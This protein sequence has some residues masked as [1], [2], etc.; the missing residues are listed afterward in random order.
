MMADASP[1]PGNVEGNAGDAD[2]VDN[3]IEETKRKIREMEEE[4]G[5]LSAILQD[6]EQQ[7]SAD[8]PDGATSKQMEDDVDSRSVYVGQV[9]YEST[10]EELQAHFQS[11]GTINR[12]TII[13]DKFTGRPKGYAYIEF[14]S[15]EGAET[16]V[17]LNESI[18]RG[19]QLKV[20]AKRQNI[21][22]FVRGRGR[23]RGRGG[24]RGGRGFRGRRGRGRGGY[25]G[26]YRG[27]SPY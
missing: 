26:G 2:S 12:V 13:C 1:P 14:E 16:A 25:R 9:D 6:I 10:P 3:K 8:G 5:K 17:S 19:R 4:D 11:C 7:M 15:V 20:T 23:G 27:H 21:P 22:G 18:F 24:F